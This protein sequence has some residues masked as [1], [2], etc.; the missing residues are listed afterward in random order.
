MERV[1]ILGAGFGGLELAT[2]LS[3]EV[4]DAVEVTLIDQSESFV[5]GYSKLDV[6]FGREKPDA[7][8]LYYRDIVKPSVEFR[9]E[10]VRSIDPAS[11][12]SPPTAV[13]TTRTCYV[14]FGARTGTS[15]P[16]PGCCRRRQRVLY[17]RRRGARA[18][19]RG[20]LRLRRRHHQRKLWAVLLRCPATFPY[21]AAMMLHDALV[22]RGVRDATTIKVLTP[23]AMPIPISKEASAGIRAGLEARGIEFWPENRRHRYRSRHA[24][25]N[26]RD[27]RAINYDLVPPRSRFIV[28]RRS[29]RIGDDRRRLDPR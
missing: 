10:T 13:H 3:E 6:M 11:G 17:G 12:R 25:C 15:S 29:S 21:E 2:R 23:M 19:R 14:A 5:F 24:T 28:H 22:R 7:V 4:P 8:H 16:D 20:V 18:R 1:L 26:A 27:G 9:Q